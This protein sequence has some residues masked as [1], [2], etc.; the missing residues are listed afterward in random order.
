MKTEKW[1]AE[2]KLSY[3]HGLLKATLGSVCDYSV[4]ALKDRMEFIAAVIEDDG[5]GQDAGILGTGGAD[6]Q[7]TDRYAARHLNNRQ[8]G[9]E[10]R[11]AFG[12]DRHAQ[13]RQRRHRRHHARQV[14]GTPCPG[15]DDL[16]PAVARA[17][18]IGD[19]TVG[20][21]MGRDDLA[22]MRDAQ[23]LQHLGRMAHRRPV[24]LAAHDN[25]DQ[26]SL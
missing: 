5:S 22:F 1:S 16:K 23:L 2:V 12:F 11:Q 18:G 20:R 25:A 14:G 24:G 10:A 4:A 13:D 8:Q 6:R 17:F 7:R 19:H 26:R 3:I 15:N 9:I 21:A